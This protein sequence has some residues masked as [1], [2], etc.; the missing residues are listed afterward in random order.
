MPSGVCRAPTATSASSTWEFKR[1]AAD[2]TSC[3]AR[4]GGFEGDVEP[5]V[6]TKTCPACP[7]EILREGA[8][9]GAPFKDTR[10]I[11]SGLCLTSNERHI[12]SEGKRQKAKGK[13][14][15]R[16]ARGSSSSTL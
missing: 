12:S 13:N 6:L 2:L 5:F 8:D 9:R 15:E 3:S 16:A 11:S 7:F 1:S 4:V 14:E 10:L